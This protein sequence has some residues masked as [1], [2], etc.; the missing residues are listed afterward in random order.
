MLRR[1]SDPSRSAL[2]SSF[3][4]E[5]SRTAGLTL[6]FYLAWVVSDVSENWE[7]LRNVSI[8]TAYDPQSALQR[9]HIEPRHLIAVGPVG[10]L[11]ALAIS[12][13]GLGQSPLNG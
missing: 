8:F 5:R 7:W 11:V 9:S 12:W 10:S 1:P 2:F 4:K 6:A 3:S 13:Q